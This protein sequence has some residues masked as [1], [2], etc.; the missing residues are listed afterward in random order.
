MRALAA[1]LFAAGTAG[2]AGPPID[3]NAPGVL[4]SLREHNPAHYEKIQAIIVLAE[5]RP[6]G[7]FREWM[8]SAFAATEVADA[9]LWQVSNPPKRKLSFTLDDTRYTATIV[10]RFTQARPI[11]IR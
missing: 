8:R 6:A 1:L 10:G 9:P 3:L 7:Q 11:P 2:A 5:A 4:E